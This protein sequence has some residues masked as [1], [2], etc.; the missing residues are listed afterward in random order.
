M[1]PTV[2]RA[3]CHGELP[4]THRAACP[5]VFD[6]VLLAGPDDQAHE[7]RPVS[8]GGRG[9]GEAGGVGRVAPANEEVRAGVPGR[10]GDR[11]VVGRSDFIGPV[12]HDLQPVAADRLAH[13]LDHRCRKRGVLVHDRHGLRSAEHGHLHGTLQVGRSRRQQL[14]T[15]LPLS[16]GPDRGRRRH[17][18]DHRHP[19][20][21]VDGEDGFRDRA[22]VGAQQRVDRAGG[23]ELLVQARARLGIAPVVADLQLHGPTANPPLLVEDLD[24]ESIPPHD[25]DPFHAVPPGLGDG[26]RQRDRRPVRARLRP[27]G[28][29]RVVHAPG[30]DQGQCQEACRQADRPSGSM[31]PIYAAP[32]SH[33]YRLET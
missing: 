7:D 13:A 8:H 18:S 23:R 11:F 5:H 28:V 12:H 20:G 16:F 21:L 19:R 17:R 29:R 15:P 32:E 6:E 2:W 3:G 25:F 22:A 4:A 14:D 30:R 26:R 1:K 24:G 10:G 27:R 9:G 33:E 31:C